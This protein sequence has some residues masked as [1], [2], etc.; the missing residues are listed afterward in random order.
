MSLWRY[1]LRRVLLLV[2]VLIGI[3]IVAFALTHVVPRNPVYALV[4]TFADQRLV[5]ETIKRYG[6]DQPL[7]VQYMRYMGNLLQG[8]LGISIRTGR[9]VIDEIRLRLPATLELTTLALLLALA[10]AL[11]LGTIAAL[12]YG[13]ATDTVAR[14]LALI[15]NSLPEFWLGLI[16][17]FVFYYLLGWAPPPIGRLAS[18]VTPPTPLTNFYLVDALLTG[19]F[20]ALRSSLAQI[21]LPVLTLAFVVMAPIMRTVRANVLEVLDAP[22]VRCANAHGL[23]PRRVLLT[24]VLRNAL[25]SVVTLV[26]IIY[27]YLLGGAVLI[28]KVYSWPGLGQWAADAILTQDYPVVQAFVLLAAAFYVLVYLVA[29][30][31]LALI[32]PRIRY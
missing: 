31:M 21:A 14:I 2:P 13:R 11:L 24:Y 7:P 27:G 3:T 1:A 32:D 19:N 29:D 15:G 20:P 9:P 8:D 6:L 10:G 18:G 22:Y 4:G 26:A 25:L 30:L 23:K 16:F 5:D 12:H 17:V 28:E